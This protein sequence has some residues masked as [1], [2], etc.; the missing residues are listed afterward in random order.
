MKVRFTPPPQAEVSRGMKVPY[1]PGRRNAAQWRW[2]LILVLVASPFVYLLFSLAWPYLTLT[3]PGV[4]VLDRENVV[5]AGAGTVHTLHLR[6]G[7]PVEVGQ[8]L[9]TLVSAALDE[10]IA[11]A[12]LAPL[13]ELLQLAEHTARRQAGRLAVVQ[14]LLAKGAATVAEVEA[15]AAEADS[16]RRSL[17]QTRREVL[18]ARSEGAPAAP[19]ESVSP[20]R[21][22]LR[23]RLAALERERQGLVTRAPLAGR[24]LDLPVETGQQ[25]APGTVL[26]QVAVPGRA[27]VEAYLRP[28][29][30]GKATPGREVTVRLPDGRSVLARVREQPSRVRQLPAGFAAAATDSRDPMLLVTFDLAE[31]LPVAL[32]IQGLPV[33][34]RFPRF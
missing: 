30:L 15:A 32:A 18:A 6:P 31:P 1:G 23:E 2:H 33:E 24:L 26:A 4:V 5:A 28:A 9:V 8:P 29:A 17:L 19:A 11:A 3:A 27:Q 22:R 10:R 7:D 12:P 21:Q 13:E 16:A 25:V 20:D 34:V 14:G